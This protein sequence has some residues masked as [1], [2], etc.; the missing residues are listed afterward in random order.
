M[1]FSAVP[2]QVLQRFRQEKIHPCPTPRYC[3]QPVHKLC[4]AN[5]QARLRLWVAGDASAREHEAANA[6]GTSS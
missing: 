5:P 4:T 1:T 3:A 6:S 2:A